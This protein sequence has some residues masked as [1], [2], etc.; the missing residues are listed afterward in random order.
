M[1]L[2]QGFSAERIDHATNCWFAAPERSPA[3]VVLR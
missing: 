1:I 2:G 3:A